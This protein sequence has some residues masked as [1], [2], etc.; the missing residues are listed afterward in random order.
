[1]SQKSDVA[2][3]SS[4]SKVVNVGGFEFTLVEPDWYES[5]TAVGI[6]MSLIG[7]PDELVQSVSEAVSQPGS[8]VAKAFSAGLRMSLGQGRYNRVPKA[9]IIDLLTMTTD[10]D[11]DWFDEGHLDGPQT[12][13][14][15]VE[16][17]AMLP[18][19]GVFRQKGELA[20]LLVRSFSSP[21]TP[22][23]KSSG[24]GADGGQTT[25]PDAESSGPSHAPVALRNSGPEPS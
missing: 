5:L 24:N 13:E 19:D 10:K 7:N 8:P 12:L 20:A 2:Q 4:E 16:V 11:A 3:M 22:P 6:A 1:M 18:F 23:A 17:S 21:S 9:D 25:S 15:V 14:L